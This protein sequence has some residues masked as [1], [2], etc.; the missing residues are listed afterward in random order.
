MDAYGHVNNVQFLRYLEDARVAMLFD[1]EI[2]FEGHLVVV[3]HEIDYRRPL[4][5]RPEP[6]L[7]RTSV[8]ELNAGSVTL[9]YEISDDESADA[10]TYA[11]ARSVL[12]AYDLGAGR[13]RRFTTAER[14]WL[15]RFRGAG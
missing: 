2:N 14:N 10:T 3:R 1:G 11:T 5:Y 13:P 9:A 7:I 8:V 6:V 4:V 12:A 15:D